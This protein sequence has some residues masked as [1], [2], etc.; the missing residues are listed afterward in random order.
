MEKG[1]NRNWNAK[2]INSI[3]KL[4]KEPEVNGAFKP[5]LTESSTLKKI[6]NWKTPGEHDYWF[7]NL[8]PYHD[9][10]VL[11]LSNTTYKKQV[12]SNEWWKGKLPWSRRTPKNGRS[13]SNY[14]PLTCLP[15]NWK[16][17]TTQIREEIYY[18]HLYRRRFRKN[19][20]NAVGEQEEQMNYDII[21][22]PRLS[23]KPKRG[24]KILLWQGLITRK[25]YY[26][27]S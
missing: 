13:P 8:R 24:G 17:L 16:I 15:V 7:K 9:R 6:P 10:L 2:W 1:K 18:S 14:R 5:G 25:A 21:D 11:Q 23:K 26:M 20:M 3:K 27:V 12:Y 19:K 22:Q 4:D